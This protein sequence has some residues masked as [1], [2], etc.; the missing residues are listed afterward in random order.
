VVALV[1]AGI[2]ALSPTASAQSSDVERA[3]ATFDF[4]DNLRPVGF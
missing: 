4:T 3:T 2:L 1:A